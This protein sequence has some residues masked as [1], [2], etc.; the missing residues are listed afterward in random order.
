MDCQ[1]R[2]SGRRSSVSRIVGALVGCLGALAL[3]LLLWTPTALAD[4]GPHVLT[5]NSGTTGINSASCAGCHR[6]HTSA[7]PLL[8]AQDD[9]LALCLSCHGPAGAGA[10]T[11]VVNGVLAGTTTGLKGGGFT[12]AHMDTDWSG[13][14]SSRPVTSAHLVDGTTDALAWGNGAIGSG[15]GASMK[16]TCVSCHNPHGTGT[17]RIL[18]D[19]PTDSG[20]AT[21]VTVTDEATPVYTVSSAQNRYFGQ[22]Y[23]GGN[24][25]RINEL[26]RWCATCHTRYDAVGPGA[27][28]TAS[29]DAIYAY[30]HTTRYSGFL[31]CAMCHDPDDFSAHDPLDINGTIAHRPACQTCHVA[32]GSAAQMG[33]FSGGVAWPDGATSPSGSARSSLLRLDNRGVCSA[34]HD[35]TR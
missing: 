6:T 18:R 28:R 2:R 13:T 34:C 32:H 14:A 1:G 16:L 8:I 30:R 10:T 29:G 9:E 35:P 7:G 25:T 4:G 27:A 21:G 23:G 15:T 3:A 19:I 12:N 20:A 17:Y 31:D 11:D 24:V 33:T 5:V 22:V 26:D